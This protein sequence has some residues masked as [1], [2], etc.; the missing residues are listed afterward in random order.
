MFVTKRVKQKF[1]QV[2]LKQTGTLTSHTTI[3]QH[4]RKQTKTEKK[5]AN[6]P[7][8]KKTCKHTTMFLRNEMP[9]AR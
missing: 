2:M 3:T 7:K 8:Q 9:N 6:T 5:Y 1:E 4:K